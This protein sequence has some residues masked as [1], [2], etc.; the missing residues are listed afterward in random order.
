MDTL[1]YFVTNPDIIAFSCL[2]IM[3]LAD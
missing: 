1:L 3:V 2:V